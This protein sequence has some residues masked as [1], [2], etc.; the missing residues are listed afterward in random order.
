MVKQLQGASTH[1]ITHQLTPDQFFRWQ[2]GYGAVTVSPRHIDQVAAYIARQ[3][4][5]HAANTLNTALELPSQ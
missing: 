1:L 5:H 2:A 3:R 4:E